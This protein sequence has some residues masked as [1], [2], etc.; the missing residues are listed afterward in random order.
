[1]KST[2]SWS[3]TWSTALSKISKELNF[4]PQHI[5]FAGPLLDLLILPLTILKTLKPPHLQGHGHLLTAP[6]STWIHS[7]LCHALLLYSQTLA[8]TSLN[9]LQV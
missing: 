5:A 3:S 4:T 8:V 9:T 6:L 7:A 2:V 1:M